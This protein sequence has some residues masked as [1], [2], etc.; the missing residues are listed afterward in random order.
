MKNDKQKKM[1]I[2]NEEVFDLIDKVDALAAAVRV[3]L[4]TIS[5]AADFVEGYDETL[6]LEG[7]FTHSV[8][9]INVSIERLGIVTD[10]V[11]DIARKALVALNEGE[12]SDSDPL[13][14]IYHAE[15]LDHVG[16]DL[17]ESAACPIESKGTC[18]EVGDD[19]K[20]N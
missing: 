8:E 4:R 17:N 5:R 6:R 10:W 12:R 13:A 3:D 9:D 19:A 11:V 14:D 16:E 15:P 1:M 7:L 20:A 2:D 18:A